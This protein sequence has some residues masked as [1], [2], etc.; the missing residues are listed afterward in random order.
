MKGITPVDTQ[1]ELFP[2]GNP[3]AVELPPKPDLEST[4]TVKEA[5]PEFQEHM[6]RK[7]FTTNT[8]KAFL[9]DMGL[10]AEFVGPE[11]TLKDCSTEKLRQFIHYLQH[12]RGAPCSP[13]SLDRRITTLKVF[14]GW[15]ADHGIVPNDPAAPLVHDRAQSPLPHILTPEQAENIL[16][17]ARSMRDADEAPDA[18]PYLLLSLLLATGIKKA[19]CMRISLK[20]IDLTDVQRPAVYIHYDKPRQRFKSRLLA[21]P[22][23]WPATL[24]IYLRRYQPKEMLFEC[25]PRNLEYVLHNISA[26]AGLRHP[27]TFEA[28]RWTSAVHSFREG[29]DEERLRKRLGL[30]RISWRETLPIIQTLAEGPL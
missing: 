6:A 23:D 20:H 29:M 7:E 1:R 30:S 8:V 11:A 15:L 25:T 19:E 16:D 13:K 26:V 2:F 9:H 27:L 12:E 22:P 14:F 18:R 24:E 17:I 28:L 10:F 3:D 21:L 4:S 5:L